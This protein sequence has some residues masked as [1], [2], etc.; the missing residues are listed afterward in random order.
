MRI[1]LADNHEQPRWALKTLFD[2]QPEFELIGDVK[3]H[4]VCLRW[5]KKNFQIWSWLIMSYLVL[6]LRIYS[7]DY[8]G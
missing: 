7:P 2:E 4:R 3:T 1:I 6:I 8:M 5:L